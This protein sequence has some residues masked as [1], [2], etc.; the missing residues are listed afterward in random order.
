MQ[1]RKGFT[2]IELLVVIAIIAILAAILFPV[3]AQAREK[4]R[5]TACLSNLKQSAMATV[6]YVQDYDE[7]FPLSVFLARDAA[8]PCTFTFYNAITPYQ[9]NSDIMRCPSNPLALDLPK[10]WQ[11][12]GLPPV[13]NTGSPL[14][15]LSY[16]YNF[17][18]IEEG[19]PNALFGGGGDAP[20]TLAEI[21]FP[22][23][24][25]MVYD[26]TLLTSTGSGC[27]LFDSPID[28]RHN[29]VVNAN[30]VDGHSKVVHARPAIPANGEGPL[31][32][33]T[34][35]AKPTKMYRVTDAGPY[36]G[37]DELWGIPFQNAD[38]TW[39]RR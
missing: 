16:V 32:C 25:A 15:F 26:G 4:A 39:G 5:Q 31:T 3:F 37:R 33:T 23:E 11:L 12:H 30:Y 21:D 19:N 24:T 29:A 2:L 6:M 17:S 8:G 35:D 9:K 38:G 28:A 14:R 10:A 1:S 36:Q 22:V 27:N 18:L 13:C 34:M 7:T 20:T